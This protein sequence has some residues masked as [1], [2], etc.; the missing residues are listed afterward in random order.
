MRGGSGFESTPEDALTYI[1]GGFGHNDDGCWHYRFHDRNP[2]TAQI[3]F[4]AVYLKR[5]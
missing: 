5:Q 2:R 4:W 1:A 3:E